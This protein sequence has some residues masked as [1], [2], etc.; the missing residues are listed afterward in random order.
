MG[1]TGYVMNENFAGTILA[2]IAIGK[3][4][5]VISMFDATSRYGKDAVATKLANNL[6]RYIVSDET[7]F[8]RPVKAGRQVIVLESNDCDLIDLKPWFNSSFIDEVASDGKGGWDD[9]GSDNDLRNMVVGRQ[10]LSGVPFQIVDPRQNNDRSCV[11]LW[12]ERLSWQPKSV[13]GIKVDGLY[14]ALYFLHTS[15]CTSGKKGDELYKFVVHFADGSADELPI[16]KGVHVAD[17]SYP[18]DTLP[19]SRLAWTGMAAGDRKMA[20]VFFTEWKNPKPKVKITSVDFAGTG[21]NVAILMAVTGYKGS[22]E[23]GWLAPQSNP[24]K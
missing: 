19:G 9:Y 3:G 20:G 24:S 1:G 7:Q 8:S 17:W 14:N 13:A 10:I 12:N 23:R 11:I 6:V 15:T 22:A 18:D 2:D 21:R 5:S 4:L 16:R